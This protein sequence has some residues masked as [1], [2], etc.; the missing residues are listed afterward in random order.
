MERAFED[1]LSMLGPGQSVRMETGSA[2]YKGPYE[3][4]IL[5][6]NSEGVRIAAA[7]G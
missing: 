3:S 1:V 4:H 5:E 6:V 7:D 2:I